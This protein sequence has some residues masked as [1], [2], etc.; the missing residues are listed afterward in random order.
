MCVN[1]NLS[2]VVKV[3]VVLLHYYRNLEKKI[4]TNKCAINSSE[5]RQLGLKFQ[6]DKT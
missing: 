4:I 6:N 2:Y 1:N 3:E 5:L